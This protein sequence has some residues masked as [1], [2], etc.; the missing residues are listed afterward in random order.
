MHAE[1]REGLFER[2][3]GPERND[4][5]VLDPLVVV[6]A[7]D[8]LVVEPADVGGLPVLLACVVEQDAVLDDL[9]VRVIAWQLELHAAGARPDA[10]LG[11]EV[12]LHLRRI[13]EVTVL[14]RSVPLQN[15]APGPSANDDLP[16]K[17]PTPSGDERKVVV[18]VHIRERN[19]RDAQHLEHV[20]RRLVRGLALARNDFVAFAVAGR[21]VVFGRELD[22]I[23]SD[24]RHDFCFSFNERT[25]HDCLPIFC[26][27]Y[28]F[29]T[30]QSR[31]DYTT[32]ARIQKEP[33]TAGSFCM[34]RVSIASLSPYQTPH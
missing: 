14:H 1:Q 24:R 31:R 18:L 16:W 30:N 21:P 13:E 15:A 6:L 17:H 12:E 26:L 9:R 8:V 7:M 28:R 10:I 34:Y 5:D 22:A 25:T 19:A 4:L 33:D 11:L 20:D 3:E 32:L 2:Q 23:R 27:S 29:T